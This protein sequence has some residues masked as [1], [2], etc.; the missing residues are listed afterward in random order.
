MS[1][2]SM[3][4]SSLTPSS[5]KPKQPAELNEM[6]ELLNFPSPS[7]ASTVGYPHIQNPE[8]QVEPTTDIFN[9][10]VEEPQ[11]WTFDL[12]AE[13]SDSLAVQQEYTFQQIYT[14][15]NASYLTPPTLQFPIPDTN[16]CGQYSPLPLMPAT[17]STSPSQDTSPH[18]HSG[19]LSS[20]PTTPLS[21]PSHLSFPE[22]T[23]FPRPVDVSQEISST[24]YPSTRQQLTYQDQIAWW[25]K[26]RELPAAGGNPFFIPQRIYKPHTTSDIKRYVEE[27]SLDPPI[28]FW[29]DGPE[30]CGISLTDCLHGRTKRLRD[31]DKEV[32]EHRGPS[33]SIRLEWPG[34]RQW[35]RQI[36]TKDFKSP[37]RPISVTK[38]CKNIAKCVQRFVLER[39][40]C[41]LE[42]GTD[43]RWKVGGS[44]IRFEDLVLVSLHHVSMGSWQPQLR[45]RTRMK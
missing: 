3:S 24:L 40:H 5:C 6:S 26:A 27:A 14:V 22:P 18:W 36:P 35:S 15:K 8:S 2:D 29:M 43:A 23:V 32:F 11:P 34:Y 19:S 39:Q 44:G 33:V 16:Y 45:F 13:F 28:C 30:E 21:F 37:P 17:P 25:K 41:E 1:S 31:R 12:P 38:L 20:T 10:Q 4:L 7:Q 9:Y 42:D